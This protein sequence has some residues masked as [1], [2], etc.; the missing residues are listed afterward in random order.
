MDWRSGLP[1]VR[2]LAAATVI[3]FLPCPPRDLT[4]VA[5][6]APAQQVSQAVRS[7][8]ALQHGPG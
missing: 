1:S 2:G 3:E 4:S 8:R 5:G 6:A 7:V